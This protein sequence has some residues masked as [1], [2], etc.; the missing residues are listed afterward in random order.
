M[1]TLCCSFA[2]TYYYVIAATHRIGD[3]G[4]IMLSDLIGICLGVFPVIFVLL[5]TASLLISQRLAP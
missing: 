5:L 1:V 2:E 3:R 4:R